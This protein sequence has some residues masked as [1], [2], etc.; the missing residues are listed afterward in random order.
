MSASIH[1]HRSAFGV[2]KVI[3]SI[4]ITAVTNFAEFTMTMLY[5]TPGGLKNLK[6]V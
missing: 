3:G 2:V 6:A 4:T 1:V 5:R